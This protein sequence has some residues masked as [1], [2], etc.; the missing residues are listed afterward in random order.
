MIGRWIGIAAV[1]F[2][3]VDI[4]YI[5]DDLNCLSNLAVEGIT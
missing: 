2:Q 1:V 4:I 5:G 3:L